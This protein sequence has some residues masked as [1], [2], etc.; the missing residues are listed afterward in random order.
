MSFQTSQEQKHQNQEMYNPAEASLV[1][2]LLEVLQPHLS[3][4][5]VGIITPYQRQRSYL[6]EKL[7]KFKGKIDICINTIDGFQVCDKC[8]VYL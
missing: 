4:K 1:C 7:I 6:E 8:K 3:D 5:T 2:V